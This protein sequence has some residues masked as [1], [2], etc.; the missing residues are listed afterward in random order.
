M[1][2]RLVDQLVDAGLVTEAQARESDA[3]DAHMPS[4]RVAENLVAAGL[5]ERALAGFF[6]MQ[7]FGPM[8]RAQDLARADRTLVGKLTGGAARE[9]YAMPLRPSPAGAIV[10]MVDPTDAGAVATLAETLGGTI[11]PTVAKLSDLLESIDIAYPPER[12]TLVTDPLALSLARARSRTP[13]GA[14]PLV[15]AKPV[16]GTDQ[17]QPS[18]DPT[19][20]ELASTASPVWDRAWNRSSPE[21]D[22]PPREAS[23][24]P[25]ASHIPLPTVS[26]TPPVVTNTPAPFASSRPAEP[27]RPSTVRPPS[28]SDSAIDAHLGE[29]ASVG[30]RD[31]VVHVA[32]QACLAA[33]RGAAFLALR[34]GVFRGWDGAGE[35]VTSAGIRSLW[36]PASNPSI[37][38]EVLHSGRVFSG[39]YGQTAADHL[40]RAALGSQGRHVIVVPVLVGVRMVGVLCANDPLSADTSAVERIAEAMGTAFE[41]LIVSRKARD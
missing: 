9:L 27:T 5:D 31:E 8:L 25:K 21:R 26:V 10:A 11:L 34:Q 36:V 32:C 12:P 39:A 7:G 19:F 2:G 6:V 20:S 15:N 13:T 17:T 40:F 33:A 16:S 24:T 28:V 3:G 18:F 37:L 35:D 14:V 30:S 4:G 29:L 1:P 38:N 23:L 41:R 22:T